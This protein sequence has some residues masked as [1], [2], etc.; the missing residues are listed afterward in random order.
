MNQPNENRSRFTGVTYFCPACERNCRILDPCVHVLIEPDALEYLRQGNPVA[1]APPLKNI[2]PWSPASHALGELAVMGSDVA[3]LFAAVDAGAT[4][5]ITGP[6]PLRSDRKIPRFGA[7]LE[8]HTGSRE[9]NASG[10]SLVAVIADIA[11]QWRKA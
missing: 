10:D 6:D 1:N 11:A 4:F 8:S 9:A 5:V 2:E 3:T 7:T